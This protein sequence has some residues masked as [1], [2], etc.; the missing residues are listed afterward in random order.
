MVIT[1]SEGGGGVCIGLVDFVSD[2]AGDFAG[3]RSRARLLADILGSVFLGDLRCL[4]GE[5]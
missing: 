5:A 2:A 4:V 1:C 3:A